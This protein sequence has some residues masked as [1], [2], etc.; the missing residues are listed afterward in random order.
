MSQIFKTI[1]FPKEYSDT[2]KTEILRLAF[3]SEKHKQLLQVIELLS[4]NEL[5]I[6]LGEQSFSKLNS[7]SIK[8]DRSLNKYCISLIENS[9]L[10]IKKEHGNEFD[11]KMAFNRQVSLNKFTKKSVTFTE[12]KTQKI[13]R[14]Y[15]YVEGYSCSFVNDIL[16]NLPYKPSAIYDPFSGSGTTQIVA[17]H[18]SIMSYYSEINPLM[19]FFIDFKVNKVIDLLNDWKNNKTQIES[20]LNFLNENFEKTKPTTH[21]EL[22]KFFEKNN[23]GVL[24]RIKEIINRFFEKNNLQKHFALF[25]LASITVLSSNMIRRSDLRYRREGEKY[26]SNSEVLQSFTQKI[27]EMINDIEDLNSSGLCLEKTELF[28]HNAKIFPNKEDIRFDLV[29]TS[30]PYANGTN[31]FRNSKLEL[32]IL[33][34]IKTTDE[35]SKFNLEAVTAGINNVTKNLP[36]PRNLPFAKAIIENLGKNSYDKRIPKMVESYFS[37]LDIVLENTSN[38]LKQN[39][40]FY[41]DIG[42]SQFN[43]V[44]VPTDEI[45]IQSATKYGLE[46]VENKFVRERFSKNG[47]PLKQVV[48]IFKKVETTKKKSNSN[49]TAVDLLKTNYYKFRELEYKKSPYSK[50]NWG[51]NLH[52]LCSYQ[53]KLKPSIAHFLVNLFTKPGMSI[54]DPLSGVGTIPFEA[55]L[56]GRKGI[57]NDLSFLAYA[58]SFAKLTRQDAIKTQ[59][60]IKKLARFIEKNLVSKSEA[61]KTV[62]GY[63]KDIKDYYED[64]TFREILTARAYFQSKK[65]L[66]SEDALILA[67]LLHILHGNR[68]YALSRRSHGVIP[69]APTGNFEYKNLVEKLTEKV[70][71]SLKAGKNGEF[72]EGIALNKDFLDL[73]NN[74]EKESV[75]AIIT[76]P[77]FLN[78]TKFYMSNWIRLWFTGWDEQDFEI[79]KNDF[80]E[81]KQSKDFLVYEKFFNTCKKLLKK[82]GV[83]IMHLGKTEK[84]DMGKLLLPIAEKHFKVFDLFDEDVAHVEKF[85][86]RDQGATHVHQFLFLHN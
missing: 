4:S 13:H 45:L 68:P 67:S 53:G 39:S 72:L 30:P 37:D 40:Y 83:I 58:N 38:K 69:F 64:R 28:S 14:W 82:D 76:S 84:V 5:R 24:L 17:S 33:D 44:H 20:F 77:P 63:N 55:C 36:T 57:A 2:G 29:I 70:N 27:L 62:F 31:Y 11:I 59:D 12:N 56:Q 23:L 71:R 46:L 85:G 9:I 8:F 79:K 66:D 74:L 54:L 80:L 22:S 49:V 47:A 19:R 75:D 81:V 52:S 15:P 16:K 61:Q 51:N 65:V 21:P 26:L 78:S 6:L 18:N 48:L 32:L 41:L 3:N 7:K 34:F 42:D 43:G 86:I 73:N 10:D 1:S 50:R 25:A 35:L 60:K